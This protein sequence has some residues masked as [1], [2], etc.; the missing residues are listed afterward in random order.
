M[1]GLGPAI[2]R[3]VPGLRQPLDEAALEHE[4]GVI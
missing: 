4:A 3:V 1:L 2:H